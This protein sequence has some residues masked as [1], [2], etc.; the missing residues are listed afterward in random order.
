[1]GK[2]SSDITERLQEAQQDSTLVRVERRDDFDDIEGYVVGVG[3]EWVLFAVLDAAI[4]LDGHAAVRLRDVRR[5][6]HRS[7]GDMV[8][9]ALALRDQWPPTAPGVPVNLDSVRD[10]VT[11]LAEVSALLTVHTERDDAD[12]CFIGA[13][14]GLGERSLRLREVNPRGSW[15]V[16]PTKYRLDRITRL[17]VGGRYEQALSSVAGPPPAGPCRG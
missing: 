6:R 14:Q 17:D 2:R 15:T 13:S 10:L 12:V 16:Q 7:N 1:M 4:V 9:R 5:I 8:R 3:G 11:S